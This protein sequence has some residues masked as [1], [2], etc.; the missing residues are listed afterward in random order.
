M[1]DATFLLDH[2]GDGGGSASYA[3][4][5]LLGNMWDQLRGNVPAEV[6]DDAD[7]ALAEF[8]KGHEG[9]PA[10]VAAAEAMKAALGDLHSGQWLEEPPPYDPIL[11]DRQPAAR[12]YNI[13]VRAFQKAVFDAHRKLVAAA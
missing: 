8:E 9:D 1:A 7:A 12:A 3:K 11:E 4:L 10:L 13:A 5:A 6:F 2:G